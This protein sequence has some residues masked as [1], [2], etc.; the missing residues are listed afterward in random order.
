MAN[1]QLAVTR[2]ME[3]LW[4]PTLLVGQ[5]S[6]DEVGGDG[7]DEVEAVGSLVVQVNGDVKDRRSRGV[8]RSV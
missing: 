1:I 7:L 3:I 6:V 8:S 2:V 4:C 5:E